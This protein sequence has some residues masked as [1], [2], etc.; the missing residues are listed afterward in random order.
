MGWERWKEYLRRRIRRGRRRKWQRQQGRID[1]GYQIRRNGLGVNPGD[2]I[3]RRGILYSG[4][5]GMGPKSALEPRR[6]R[7]RRKRNKDLHILQQ[8]GIFD[9]KAERVETESNEAR[10]IELEAQVFE[11]ERARA[12]HIWR[13]NALKAKLAESEERERERRA[14]I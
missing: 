9:V 7:R 6:R 13:E 11:A 2:G 3:S 4:H 10:A 5:Q 12:I 14:K 8:T 1:E